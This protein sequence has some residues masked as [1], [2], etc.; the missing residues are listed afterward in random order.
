MGTL[1]K[2]QVQIN[3]KGGYCREEGGDTKGD[4]LHFNS[5]KFYSVGL[6]LIMNRVND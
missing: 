2:R 6:V 5:T 4:N 1:S 3:I